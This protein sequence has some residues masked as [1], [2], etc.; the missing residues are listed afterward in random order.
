MGIPLKKKICKGCGNEW[1]IWARGLCVNCHNKVNPQKPIKRTR[2][3]QKEKTCK[4]CGNERKLWS[5]GM[6]YS[7][8]QFHI[9][10][11]SNKKKKRKAKV[12]KG[13]HFSVD[14]LDLCLDEIY[15]K[16]IRL[17]A[18]NDR[19]LCKCYTCRTVKHWKKMQ[20]GHYDSRN[21][22]QTKYFEKNTKPQC[23][24]CN[25]LKQGNT[26]VYRDVLVAEYGTEIFDELKMQRL[27]GKRKKEFDFKS[28]I[29]FY[30]NR[31]KAQEDRLE[32]K[33]K[34]SFSVEKILNPE[35]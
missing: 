6:C 32:I 5:S 23:R 28:A 16:V 35:K 34:L 9:R 18:S 26:V 25:I 8:Y 17:E 3:V 21:V 10:L 15:S 24:D 12:T 2:L 29:R 22:F 30:Y 1:Y 19:Q 11:E 31:L 27:I 20:N 14:Y 4:K 13:G 7:C 33:V